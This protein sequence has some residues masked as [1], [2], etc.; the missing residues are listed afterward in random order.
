MIEIVE[1]ACCDKTVRMTGK[2]HY[3]ATVE[4]GGRPATREEVETPGFDD[5]E[6]CIGLH[7]VGGGCARKLRKQ[8]IYVVVLPYEGN[9]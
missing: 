1:C 8:G 6:D 9:R 4:Y 2:V 7:P 3:V 5:R